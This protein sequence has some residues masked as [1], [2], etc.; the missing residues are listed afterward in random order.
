M[1]TELFVDNDV[2]IKC[3]CYRF[4]PYIDAHRSDVPTVAIL[5]AARFVVRSHLARRGD[6]RDREAARTAFEEYLGSAIELEPTESEL[7]TATAIEEEALRRGLDLDSGESQLCAMAL[8]RGLAIVLTGDKRAIMAIEQVSASIGTLTALQGRIA[9]LEQ[10]VNGIAN[11]IGP[12]CARSAIC[13]EPKV[14]TAISIC[15]ECSRTTARADFSPEGLASYIED[16]RS[17]APTMLYPLMS[18]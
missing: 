7:A 2:L 1:A 18:L 12:A 17:K 14:D 15:F 6:I 13:A 9:C 10:A 4:L 11:R 8:H 5:G 16:L 3:S